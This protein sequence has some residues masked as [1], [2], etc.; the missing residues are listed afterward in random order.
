LVVRLW[1]LYLLAVVILVAAVA[2]AHL[3]RRP[4]CRAPSDSLARGICP[5]V[6]PSA[7]GGVR[8]H[9]MASTIDD[10]RHLSVHTQPVEGLWDC[11]L[12]VQQAHHE[13]LYEQY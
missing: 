11:W 9:F 4:E 5:A 2:C 7:A 8:L 6:G 13:R 10:R 1:H 12:V 3:M